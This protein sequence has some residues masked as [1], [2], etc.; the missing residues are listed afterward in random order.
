MD[1]IIWRIAQ[2][3]ALLFIASIIPFHPY[4][5]SF[6]LKAIPTLALGWLVLGNVKSRPG[7]L[8]V[9]GLVLSTVGD[10]ALD[11]DRNRFFIIGLG[12]FLLA[13]L[14]YISAMMHNFGLSRSK[15]PGIVAVAA[16]GI[17][18]GFFLRDIPADKFIPVM[19]YL[20]AITIMVMTSICVS[21]TSVLLIL[22]AAI[23]MLSDTVIAINK[24]LHPIP[25]STVFNIGLYFVAQLT[26]VKGFI[27]LHSRPH[28]G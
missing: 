1:L 26:L 17:T 21:P 7:Y 18:L 8:L 16:F 22:G 3:A 14:L 6:V 10:I 2:V 13:H 19:C 15:I 9:A 28:P 5:G 11:L 4:P 12:A 20:G 27:K 25:H 23:F 24:F